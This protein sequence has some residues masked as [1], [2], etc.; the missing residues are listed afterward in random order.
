MNDQPIGLKPHRTLLGR[1]L[2]R[3]AAFD[4]EMSLDVYALHE[5]RLRRLEAEVAALR[6]D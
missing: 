6:A 4:D 2:D 1:W 5:R 3:L